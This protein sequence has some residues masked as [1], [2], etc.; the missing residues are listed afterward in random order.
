MLLWSRDCTGVGGACEFNSEL[1]ADPGGHG[2]GAVLPHRRGQ[3]ADPDGH[4][5]RDRTVPRPLTEPPGGQSSGM[6][7]PFVLM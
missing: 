3:R 4:R 7:E 2:L 5:L 1:C 6:E